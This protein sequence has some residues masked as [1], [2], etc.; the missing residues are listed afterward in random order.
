MQQLNTAKPPIRLTS[1]RLIHVLRC[2]NLSRPLPCWE[3]FLLTSD[4]PTISGLNQGAGTAIHAR[5]GEPEWSDSVE[6]L[7]GSRC[8]GLEQYA[9]A[10]RFIRPIN[11]CCA[12]IF[13]DARPC[14]NP[15]LCDVLAGQRHDLLAV[16]EPSLEATESRQNAHASRQ[17]QQVC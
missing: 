16:E 10:W 11:S 6:I 8:F 4:Q 12:D 13:P 17:E 7:Q 2:Q 9:S 14:A 1:D 3:G 15:R 5:Y